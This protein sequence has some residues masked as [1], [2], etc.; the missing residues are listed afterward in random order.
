MRVLFDTSVIVA[1]MVESHPCHEKGLPWLKK[2]HARKVELIIAA[3]TLAELYAVLSTLPVRPRI[4]PGI[5]WHLI[6]KN[7]ISTAKIISLTPSEYS[8]AIKDLSEKG[9][10]GGIIYD[11]LIAKT[12]LKAKVDR[13]V[14]FNKKD[15][16]KIWTGDKNILYVPE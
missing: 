12:A 11:A 3:H 2:A 8:M 5:A 10:S 6:H 4:S 14:T 16:E 13:L 9:L 7:I 1:A 15:F